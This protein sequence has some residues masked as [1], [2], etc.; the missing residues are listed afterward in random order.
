LIIQH[1]FERNVDCVFFLDCDEFINIKNREELVKIVTVLQNSQ[2]AGSFRWV[3]C[4]PDILNRS[5]FQY[6]SAIWKCTE[7][8]QYSKVMIPRSVYN[9]F[10]GNISFSQGNHQVLG[11]D[12]NALNTLEVGTLIHVPVRSRNQM[13]QKTI[14]SSMAHL[15]REGRKPGEGYQFKEMLKPITSG[16]LSDD[17]VRGC[18]NLYQKAS[19]IAP[20]SK[21]DLTNGLYQKTSLK[22]L[23]ITSTQ[24]FSF[25]PQPK[26]PCFFERSIAE[27]I[28]FWEDE[29]PKNLRYDEA[30]GKIFIQK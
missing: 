27:Q 25:V 6:E 20:I 19:R 14:L 2:I 16:E 5:Q 24:A 9:R 11:S 15:S 13:I 21:I 18:V 12:G 22:K 8:S 4:V 10:E 23:K 26:D 28:L 29:D 17:W 1:L 3:N 7:C 30:T